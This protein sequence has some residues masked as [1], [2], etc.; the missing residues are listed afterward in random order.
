MMESTLDCA[1]TIA[2]TAAAGLGA[3]ELAAKRY[4]SVLFSLSD[5]SFQSALTVFAFPRLECEAKIHNKGEIVHKY[6][7]VDAKPAE[8]APGKHLWDAPPE[9]WRSP[10]S[11]F[12]ALSSEH[13]P[14]APS[15]VLGGPD[16]D[17]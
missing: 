10:S 14:L 11:S 9:V 4:R 2:E 16:P 17:G 8:L 1:F 12:L 5:A 3:K 6:V 7:Q 13:S 15:S